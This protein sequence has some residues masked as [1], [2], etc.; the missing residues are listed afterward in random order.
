MVSNNSIDQFK[1][2]VMQ[3]L[4]FR[5]HLS[6]KQ[7]SDVAKIWLEEHPTQSWLDLYQIL[8]DN[9][10]MFKE[11]ILA[12]PPQLSA[13]EAVSLAT[14]MQGQNGVEIKN[15]WHNLKPYSN[16]FVGSEAVEWLKQKKKMT[17]EEAIAIGQSLLKQNLIHHVNH[18]HDFKDDLLFYRF[19]NK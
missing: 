3:L 12:S 2:N 1:Q 18:D 19:S 7:C 16:C 14:E 15:R 11:G 17:K 10:V 9:K 13:K 6:I 4:L 8:K 5:Y